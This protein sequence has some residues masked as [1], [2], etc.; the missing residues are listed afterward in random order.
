[1]CCLVLSISL[2]KNCFFLSALSSI[3]FSF[4]ATF[5]SV[6]SFPIMLPASSTTTAFLA[7]SSAAISALIC[8]MSF[9]SSFLAVF[10]ASLV[11][12]LSLKF[13][14]SLLMLPLSPFLVSFSSASFPSDSSF[15][16]RSFSFSQSLA[17]F[18][19]SCQVTVHCC[20]CPN[21]TPYP[22]SWRW[23]LWIA[24]PFTLGTGAHQVM[25]ISWVLMST[26]SGRSSL[27]GTPNSVITCALE[28]LQGPLPILFMARMRNW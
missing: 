25:S 19:A 17:M 15:S 21:S 23:K 13:I 24:L 11:S 20:P 6:F 26:T 14:M 28:S 1:M 8:S 3:Q 27:C 18:L 16:L 9:S 7:S 5:F 22:L 12:L 2:I 10:L 4:L